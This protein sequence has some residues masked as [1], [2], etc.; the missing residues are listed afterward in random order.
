MR[1]AI[2]SQ[3]NIR[4]QKK[5][6]DWGQERYQLSLLTAI[7][8]LRKWRE[9]MRDGR[10]R[11]KGYYQKVQGDMYIIHEVEFL[12]LMWCDRRRCRHATSEAG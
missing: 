10:N 12:L 3:G 6:K 5:A 2:P 11:E 9:C 7:G 4:Q 1:E 8:G